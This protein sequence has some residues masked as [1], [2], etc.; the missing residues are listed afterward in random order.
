MTSCYSERISQFPSFHVPL[1]KS[2]RKIPQAQQV[3]LNI[4]NITECQV[5]N[6][7]ISAKETLG[8]LRNNYNYIYINQD[9]YVIKNVN[10]T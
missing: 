1:T 4:F 3:H 10:Y 8:G 5:Y 6:P 9:E 7:M 2:C